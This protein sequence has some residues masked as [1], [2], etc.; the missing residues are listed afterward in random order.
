MFYVFNK[1]NTAFRVLAALMI[2]VYA[3]WLTPGVVAA[4]EPPIEEPEPV[5]AEILETE[6]AEPSKTETGGGGDIETGDAVSETTLESNLNYTET[7][8]ATSSAGGSSDAEVEDASVETTEPSAST[9]ETIATENGSSTASTTPAHGTT[10]IAIENAA[11]STTNATTTANSGGNTAVGADGSITT[12]DAVAYVDVVNV[13]NTNIT[14]STG[15]MDFIHNTLGHQNID[16]RNDFVSTFVDT[17]T[18]E[19]TSPCG[20]TVCGDTAV[21]A[22]N[23]AVITNDIV[24]TANSGGNQVGADGSITTGDAYA[25]AN[26]IN[27]ANTNITDSNYLLLVFNNFNDLSGD[28]VLPSSSFFADI[29]AGPHGGTQAVTTSNDATV[30]N[31]VAVGAHT[32]DNSTESGTVVT[33]SSIATA[34]VLNQLN[35]NLVNTSSFSMLIR[36]HGEWSGDIYGLPEGMSWEQTSDGVRVYSTSGGSGSGGG[37]HSYTNQATISNDVEVYALTG[38]N[39]AGN[40]GSITTGDAVADA[41]IINIA[42][43][44]VVSSNWSNLIFSI[45]GDWNGNLSFGATDLWLGV[46]AES[47]RT[48]LMPGDEVRYTYTVFNMG[49]VTARDVMLNIQTELD[50]LQFTSGTALTGATS[51]YT[52]Q[53]NVPDLAPGETYEFTAPASIH[54][55]LPSDVQSAVPLYAH[56]YSSGVDADPGNNSDDIIVYVGETRSNDA[57]Y[58]PRFPAKLTVTKT[59]TAATAQIGDTIDYTITIHNRGG[60]LFEALLVDTLRDSAGTILNEQVWPLD[61]IRNDDTITVEYSIVLDGT[62]NNTELTNEAQVVGFHGSTVR[63]Y[64]VAYES[65]IASHTLTVGEPEARVLGAST[66]CTPYLTTY[67]RYGA[68]NDATDTERLNA[69]LQVYT[70]EQLEV[71]DQFT[72]A[73]ERAVRQFQAEQAAEVLAPW[74]IAGPTGYVY[75]TTQKRINEIMC[76]GTVAFPLSSVQLQEIAW[77]RN[78]RP[79]IASNTGGNP[80]PEASVA[81]TNVRDENQ[82]QWPLA[83]PSSSLLGVWQN[84]VESLAKRVRD[85]LSIR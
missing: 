67:L 68:A 43:T 71:T 75:Y 24:V 64:Q 54:A 83:L 19:S 32:G 2:F 45:Y 16:L 81:Q 58:S 52:R 72:A 6:T 80:T 40:N 48:P 22:T 9:T 21:H 4:N 78:Q 65:E 60:Q 25:S 17:N 13:V 28:I 41:N 70:D 36:V 57:N 79:T 76:E 49:D 66:T 53:W 85:S 50:S 20:V 46:Q 11:T 51:T 31:D 15:L 7:E 44:N 29:F 77:Y 61:T 38:D 82:T 12:G 47:A 27:V 10:T 42:N 8:T 63:K 5:V 55:G 62:T 1:H 34:N 14:D 73:T 74:G 69:F 23:T 56:V 84:R 3:A 26:I 18:A 33:G 37:S 30:T 59:A 39:R 35:T